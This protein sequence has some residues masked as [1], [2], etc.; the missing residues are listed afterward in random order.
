[1]VMSHQIF[2]ALALFFFACGQPA[3]NT[4]N[5]ASASHTAAVV[6]SPAATNPNPAIQ[7][8]AA[9]AS[10]LNLGAYV[11]ESNAMGGA[12]AYAYPGS[13][14][15]TRWGAPVE[16]DYLG[17]GGLII[18]AIPAAVAEVAA[19]LNLQDYNG[20][21]FNKDGTLQLQ[22]ADGALQLG[23]PTDP[24]VPFSGPLLSATVLYQGPSGLA[25]TVLSAAVARTAAAQGFGAYQS[26]AAGSFTFA[27]GVVQVDAQGNVTGFAA[28]AVNFPEVVLDATQLYL[29]GNVDQVDTASTGARTYHC[30][31]GAVYTD[32]GAITSILVGRTLIPGVVVQAV[33]AVNATGTT[34]YYF[35][36]TTVDSQTLSYNF[37][38][39]QFT[40]RGGQVVGVN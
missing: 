5:G 36:V 29:L 6:S 22:F 18:V 4:T 10:G 21:S 20:F 39:R 30:D 16:V 34:G 9:I 19:Q 23:A 13:M 37:A 31:K 1:M 40:V 2:C 15:Q 3:V 28:T 24:G 27:T 8:A 17:Q 38:F 32:G 26:Q 35:D 7:S 12:A 11:S 33:A 14:I 25:T